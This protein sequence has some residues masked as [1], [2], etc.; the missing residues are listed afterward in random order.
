MKNQNEHLRHILYYYFKE[1]K[2]TSETYRKL[3]AVNGKDTVA[4]IGIDKDQIKAIIVTD[5]HITAREIAKMVNSCKTTID[6]HL[7]SLG[8]FKKLDTWVPLKLNEIHLT[9]R[10]NFCNT[11]LN[12]NEN[13]SFLKNLVTGDEKWIVY[14]TLVTY[15]D[16]L[17]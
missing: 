11:L 12:C 1:G 4:P 17:S 16:L 9:Q 5:R 8:Y 15:V 13:N 6:D 7:E 2:K 3:C 10:I 14:I